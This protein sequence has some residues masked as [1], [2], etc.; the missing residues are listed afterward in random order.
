VIQADKSFGQHF[1]VNEGV[2]AKIVERVDSYVRQYAPETR[3]VIEIGPGPGA[4]TKALLA[5]GLRVHAV[6]LDSRMIEHLKTNFADEIAKG[7]LSLE[8]Q[9][10]VHAESSRWVQVL[11]P[12]FVV[13][14]NLPYNAGSE[15]VFRAL[16]HWGEASGFVFMLQ[17]EVVKKFSSVF[18]PDADERRDYGPPSVKLSWAAKVEGRFWVSAGSFSPPPKVESGVFWFHRRDA[19]DPEKVGDPLV[20]NDVYDRASAVVKKLFE[21]RRKKVTFAFSNLK[22]TEFADSRAEALSPL[23]L[24]RLSGLVHKQ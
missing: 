15:I 12:S 18:F 3:A 17:K 20:R 24:F 5:R 13:C 8:Q 2:I 19:N 4:L 1:L 9:D 21:H 16:E 10:A 22:N 11:G 7:R 23:D 6:E 14:G